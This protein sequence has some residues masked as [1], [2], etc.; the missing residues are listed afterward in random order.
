MITVALTRLAISP[1]ADRDLTIRDDERDFRFL[2][3]EWLKKRAQLFTRFALAG[4]VGQVVPPN[5]WLIAVDYRHEDQVGF[6]RDKLP[7]YAELVALGEHELFP[8]M[9]RTRTAAFSTDV[10]TLRLD[11]DDWVDPSF[12][13]R[14]AELSRPNRA[15]NFPHGAQY[16]DVDG[17]LIHRW[18]RSN[19]M[20]GFRAVGT[21]LNV[22]DFGNHPNVGRTARTIS[23]PTWRPMWVKT[24]HSANHVYFQPRG[25]PVLF[26]RRLRAKFGIREAV[27]VDGV[28]ANVRMFVSFL[29]LLLNRKWPSLTKS[30]K[31]LR[32]RIGSR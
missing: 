22:H 29:G 27:S 8:E 3:D 1:R 20:V 30:L 17:A 16:F 14:A 12:V 26:A 15:I 25:V 2:D 9:V 7:P 6:L 13:A 4:M 24:A 32:A 11:A 23:I 5:L 18:I 10:L 31:R 19:P 28:S 21:D